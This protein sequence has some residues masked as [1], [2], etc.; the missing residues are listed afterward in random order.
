MQI[1]DMLKEV[2]KTYQV[3]YRSVGVADT[4]LT[5]VRLLLQSINTQ[6]VSLH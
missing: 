3:K 2:S 1:V 4:Y 6:Y 5:W